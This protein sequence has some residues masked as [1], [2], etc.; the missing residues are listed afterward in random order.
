MGLNETDT[1][2]VFIVDVQDGYPAAQAGIRSGDVI[3]D[4]DGVQVQT[5]F[6]LYAE[7]LKHDVGDAVKLKVYRDGEYFD[8]IVQLAEAPYT[9]GDGQ[10]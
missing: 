3:V 8:F 6:E 5:P 2:G 7:M 4:F 10:E 9:E 1:A